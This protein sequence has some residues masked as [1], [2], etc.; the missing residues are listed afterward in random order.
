MFSFHF[1]V[2]WEQKNNNSR[3]SRREKKIYKKT[4]IKL[5][6]KYAPLFF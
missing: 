3:Y 1:F 5:N 6:V 4:S 2:R